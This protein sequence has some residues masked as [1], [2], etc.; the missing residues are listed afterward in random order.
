MKINFDASYREVL[1]V[2]NSRSTPPKERAESFGTLLGS[3]SPE[4]TQHTDK[5]DKIPSQES[6]VRIAD[7]DPMA[8]FA[9]SEPIMEPPELDIPQLEKGTPP[10][11]NGS[12]SS[13]KTPSLV[14][15]TRQPSRSTANPQEI[16]KIQQMVDAAGRR[17]GVDPAL[18]IAVVHS[19]SSFNVKAV[20][21]DGHASKGLFQL[22]DTTGK[23]WHGRLDVEENYNPFNAGMNVDLGINYLRHLHEI[24]STNTNL[25]NNTS[26]IAAANSSSLE[27]L[28]VAAFNAG[29]GRVAAAQARALKAGGDPS[30]YEEVKQ[31]LPDSTQEYVTRVLNYREKYGTRNIG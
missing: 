5:T 22:L 21:A 1:K 18:G 28:A 25:P 10:E 2:V 8:R 31:Y 3:I 7:E 11:V 14:G 15:A 9:F 20:S 16:E 30:V 6:T 4:A 17:F 26:T 24:F 23:Q 19:E 12:S 27:K 13:V 29:E